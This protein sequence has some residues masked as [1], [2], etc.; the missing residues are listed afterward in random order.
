M[1]TFDEAEDARRMVAGHEVNLKNMEK[2]SSLLGEAGIGEELITFLQ[3]VEVSQAGKLAVL[4]A[5]VDGAWLDE[6]FVT[7]QEPAGD[8]E[9]EAQ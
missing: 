7:P 3:K 8:T 2:Y 4:K 6:I 5:M 1:F 9:E